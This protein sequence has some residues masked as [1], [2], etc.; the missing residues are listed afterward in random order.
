[1]VVSTFSG[2]G[3]RFDAE[4]FDQGWTNAVKSETGPSICFIPAFFVDPSTFKNIGVMDGGFNVR[5]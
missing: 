2:E 5:R 4:S 3:C 1:M